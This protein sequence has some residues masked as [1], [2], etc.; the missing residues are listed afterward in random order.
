MAR[1]DKTH[2][3]GKNKE[4]LEQISGKRLDLKQVIQQTVYI[5]E[6]CRMNRRAP[7]PEKVQPLSFSEKAMESLFRLTA[8]RSQILES[9][10]I[11]VDDEGN[12]I[13]DWKS[14]LDQEYEQ[15]LANIIMEVNVADFG[16]VGDGKTDCTDAFK[17][18]LGTGRVKVVVPPGVF[19]TKG[20]RLPSWT[21]L[22]GKG[23]GSTTIKLHDQASK[24]TRLI[25][26]A[27]HWRGNHHIFVQG[28]S[29]DW[30]VERI[31]IAAKTSTWGNH[32]SCLTYANVTYGWVKDVEGINPG[33]HCFDIS[34]TQYNYAGD[35]YRARGG[36]KYVW[37]DHVS[38]YGF[39]D[40][41]ITTHHSDYIF[42]SNSHICDP[43]GRAHQKGFSNSNGIEVDDGSRN[44]LLANNSSARCFGGVEIKAHQNSSA[45][46]NVQIVGH[47]SV[48][49]N[50]A[51]NFRH[52]GHHKI[53]DPESQS[54][55]NIIAVNLAAIEPI[56]T[57]LYKDS[58]PRGMVISAYKN[59]VVNHFTLVGDPNYDYK[60]NPLVALQYRARNVFL[61]NIT[62]TDFNKAGAMIKVYGG[63]NRADSI[64]I[65]TYPSEKIE[66]GSGVQDITIDSTE[67]VNV[68]F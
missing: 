48:N 20:I 18:A 33:L 22:I 38:G 41:G 16:A 4:L 39:G 15:L 8:K 1:Y 27:N 7:I 34:S 32:S 66:I 31:G 28:M 23:K 57:D 55:F 24:G 12:V 63:D 67:S 43:S 35:G 40:D 64:K 36:S 14:K 62:A 6:Q 53:T 9:T 58:A 26:N 10:R 45:A 11:L 25:T 65:L 51:F 47:L 60:R 46:N 52:I 13:P 5:F 3:P 30:N 42:I 50:R 29:L 56:F 49:D 59:V 21:C 68:Y 37:L 54:A 61:D 44:V 2:D 19:I 17:R